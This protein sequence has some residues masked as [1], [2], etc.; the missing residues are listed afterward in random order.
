MDASQLTNYRKAHNQFM[1]YEQL[2]KRGAQD[3][4]NIQTGAPSFFMNGRI[5]IQSGMPV[6][7]SPSISY[8]YSMNESILQAFE[9]FLQWIVSKGLGPTATAR[10]LYMW[11][12]AVAASWNWV[13]S[14]N[15]LNS[16]HDT[17]NFNQRTLL[18]EPMKVFIWTNHAM[19]DTFASLFPGYDISS[20]IIQERSIFDWT[21]QQQQDAI[22][23]IRTE[24]NWPA[25]WSAWQTWAAYRNGDGSATYLTQQPTTTEVKNF[26]IQLNVYNAPTIPDYS[27]PHDASKWTPLYNS[28][29][30]KKQKYLT[31]F[32][33]RVLSTGIT[34][35]QEIGMDNIADQNYVIGQQRIDE[36]VQVQQMTATLNDSGKLMA[37]FWAGGPNT[38]TPP[39]MMG[40]FWK[41]YV[42][43]NI[44]DTPTLIFSGLDVGIHLFEGSRITWRNK[45]RKDQARPVQELR[46]MNN[47]QSIQSWNGTIAGETWVPYQEADFVTPPFAD[48]PSGHSHFSQGLA[49]TMNA[50]FGSTIPIKPI[51]KSDLTLLSPIFNGTDSQTNSL[52]TITISTG[53][54]IIQPG[55]VPAAPTSLTWTTWQDMADSAGYSRLYGGI[56]C[57]SA[58]LAS[59]AVA[60]QLHTDLNTVWGF[61][62]N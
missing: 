24:A 9:L 54:S 47:G 32:W 8:N 40:W 11:F 56:H 46:I 12:M 27:A 49:N 55:A 29:T 19:V 62:R 38:V 50:W 59:Q 10:V 30:S 37:E 53:K 52:N 57:L 3:Q 51:T 18:S 39:G 6:L 48:F 2:N 25:F 14:Q 16:T 35:V 5:L 22:T 28:I 44:V 36:L 58:H 13:S 42:S 34:T 26:D 61:N 33:D 23:N 17:W 7:I 1:Y 60:S 4:A 31:Y 21:V 15:K 41:E 45:V 20:I 43:T